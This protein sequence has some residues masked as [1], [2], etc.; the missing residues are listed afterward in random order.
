MSLILNALFV[1]LSSEQA[2]PIKCTFSRS[3]PFMF[4]LRKDFFPSY[5][6]WY[7]GTHES[8][9]FIMRTHWNAINGLMMCKY[10]HKRFYESY[11][12]HPVRFVE[13]L[14]NSSD[15][16]YF[17]NASSLYIYYHRPVIS[18]LFKVYIFPK[19]VQICYFISCILWYFDFI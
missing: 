7:V 15:Q 19:V 9:I 2:P 3:P 13:F 6:T 14:A 11:P 4:M 8:T 12:Q 5:V 16:T 18:F 10:F 17:F 1:L